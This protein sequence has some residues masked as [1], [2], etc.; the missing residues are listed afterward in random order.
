MKKIR[1]MQMIDSLSIGG[2]ERVSVNYAN[3]ISDEEEFVSFHCCTREEGML[4]GFL[5][6]NVETFFMNKKS[7]MDFFSHL[8]LIKYIRKNKISIIHAHSTSF[9]TALIIKP[10]TGIKIVWH[11]HYGK[12]DYI[13]NRPTSIFKLPSVFFSYVITVNQILKKWA[14]ETLLIDVSKIEYIPNY[15]DLVFDDSIPNIPGKEGKRIVLL[16]NLRPQ[17]DHLNALKAFKKLLDKDYKDWSL[18]LVGR[19]FD[20]KY[21]ASLKRYIED[22]EV[23]NNVFI[24]GS[25]NDTAQILK[26][27]AIGLL[28][29]KSEGLPVAL[30]EYALASIAVVV[31]DVG[32]CSSVLDNGNI[33]QLIKSED[34]QVLSDAL[35]KYMSSDEYRIQEAKKLHDYVQKN[36][37]K[38]SIMKHIISKYKDI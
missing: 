12:S 4:K 8:K 5:S 32:E 10:F 20:D 13:Q 33:G 37:S 14:D 35:E 29:S 36:Y 27:C 17:K 7:S 38:K 19:D 31:S 15:A 2:A 24:L 22:N 28:S 3:A 1:V 23:A 30:L 21:S 11:D 26:N 6:E 18:L 25:R 16:A 9:L 34:S